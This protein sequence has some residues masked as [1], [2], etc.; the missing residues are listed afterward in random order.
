R[1]PLILAQNETSSVAGAD[2]VP[3]FNDKKE[4]ASE[5][6]Q[7]FKRLWERNDVEGLLSLLSERGKVIMKVGFL[8]LDGEYGKSQA[9][10]IMK[11]FFEGATKRRFSISR[12]RELSG[13]VSAYAAGTIA[14]VDEKTGLERKLKIF[15]S[16]E[17]SGGKWSVE[18]FRI[19]DK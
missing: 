1:S 17:E 8:G 7:R 14:Y 18:E 13:G 5:L 10:Y 2:T 16:L 6:L 4:I 15:I 11:E 3:I 9:E 19:S 12:Y